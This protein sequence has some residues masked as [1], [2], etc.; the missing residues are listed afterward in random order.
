MTKYVY[1]IAPLTI[2]ETNALQNAII[3]GA[4]ESRFK[5]L[6]ALLEH[7]R[8]SQAGDT[9]EREI[10]ALIR[11]ARAVLDAKGGEE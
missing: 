5:S 11:A 2:D 7:N 6:R 9:V 1:T 10:D 4:L 3:A 8:G